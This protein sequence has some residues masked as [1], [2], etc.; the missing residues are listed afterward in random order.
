MLQACAFALPAAL[1]FV[2]DRLA[3]G[4]PVSAFGWLVA[5]VPAFLVG[6]ALVSWV[7][8][9]TAANLVR[10]AT[11]DLLDAVFRHL[12]RLPLGFFHGRPVADLIIRL[13]GADAV[14]DEL[15]DQMISAL[16][17]ALIA[18]VALVALFT[19]YPA[20]SGLVL[21]AAALQGVLTW[22]A[23]RF[24]LDDFIR[25]ILSASRLYQLA[26]STLTGIADAKMIGIHRVEPAWHRALE[27]RLEARQA[28][29]QQRAVEGLQFAAQMG[30]Q[31]VVLLAGASLVARSQ[32]SLG[33]A[34]G[35]YSLA[36]VCLG[37]I[38]ALAIAAYA[39]LT[40]NT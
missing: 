14:L 13:Q 33:A 23:Q 32:M 2:V 29:G 15:L 4:R 18:L 3:H 22:L 21:G 6:Y 24:T 19:L 38:S 27:Q 37:P 1:T 10:G 20:M 30:A 8:G 35:F 17:D 26:G 28:G 9:A 12:L 31:L 16:L 5:G 11:R 25:D 36:G 39:A 7:R 40:L 34:V